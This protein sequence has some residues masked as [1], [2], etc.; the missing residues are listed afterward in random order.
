MR[1]TDNA[2]K[3]WSHFWGDRGKRS[4]HFHHQSI[5]QGGEG[6]SRFTVVRMRNRVDTATTINT[7][8]V[9]FPTQAAGNPLLPTLVVLD[10]WGSVPRER[11]S[12]NDVFMLW[13]RFF[14]I[15]VS[16]KKF[17]SFENFHRRSHSLHCSFNILLIR[18]WICQMAL[19]LA[20]GKGFL[21]LF[22]F[23]QREPWYFHFCSA[24]RKPRTKLNTI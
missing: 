17:A 10:F 2:L 19:N 14:E 3:N 21:C 13:Y 6:Q 23:Y 18:T 5:V 9:C 12:L 22:A 16:Y 24:A 11:L 7:T 1:I 4:C 8:S 15:I 20:P